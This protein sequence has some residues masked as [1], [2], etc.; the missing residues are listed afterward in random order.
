MANHRYDGMDYISIETEYNEKIKKLITG[1]KRIVRS[2]SPKM[3]REAVSDTKKP[4]IYKFLNMM[5]PVFV[6]IKDDVAVLY[7]AKIMEEKLKN[8]LSK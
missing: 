3:I 2:T 6:I 7:F 8:F 5:I 1:K 4:I